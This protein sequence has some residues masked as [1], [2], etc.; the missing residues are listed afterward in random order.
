LDT[1]LPFE[2]L[3]RRSHINAAAHA[4]DQAADFSERIRAGLPKPAADNSHQRGGYL[5]DGNAHL[6][7]AVLAYSDPGSKPRRQ[8]ARDDDPFEKGQFGSPGTPSD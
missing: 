7:D 6:A 1:R 5:R 3:K 2:E 8:H 4:A